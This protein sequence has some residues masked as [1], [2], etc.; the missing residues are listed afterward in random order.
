MTATGGTKAPSSLDGRDGALGEYALRLYIA[1]RSTKSIAAINNLNRICEAHLRGR[2]RLEIIDLV[3]E[4]VRA[5]LD[6]ILAIPT[7][8]RMAPAPVGRIIGDLSDAERVLAG[9]M[10]EAAA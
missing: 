1:G 5:R 7:L 10:L 2:Y 9:L 6:Q 4:P 8:V 3:L